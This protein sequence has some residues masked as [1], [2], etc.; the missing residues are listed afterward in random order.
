MTEG[1]EIDYDIV[2]SD[3]EYFGVCL[4]CVIILRVQ[5]NYTF[6][7]SRGSAGVEDVGHVCPLCIVHA[8]LHLRLETRFVESQTQEFF[9]RHG[10]IVVGM[11]FHLGVEN[12]DVFQR[13]AKAHHTPRGVVLLLFAHKNHANLRIVHHVLH[14]RPSRGGIKRHLH[15]AC[16]KT[17]K[18]YKQTF[19]F[20]L[21]K[22]RHIFL[23]SH[24]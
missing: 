18:F 20:I 11:A 24:S 7:L 9:K 14:L 12:N 23:H 10:N 19:G 6:R 22:H 13:M 4:K 2:G 15:S 1:Q 16:T 5:Q 8:A 21:W 3:F 17:T